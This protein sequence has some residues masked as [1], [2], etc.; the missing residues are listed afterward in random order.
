MLV[1]QPFLQSD[2]GL[3]MFKPGKTLLSELAKMSQGN[4]LVVM[5]LPD[6]LVNVPSGKLN[7]PVIPDSSNSR[8][9]DKRLL[10]FFTHPTV[11]RRLGDFNHWVE[12]IP[13][14]QLSDGEYC[15]QN[16]T[17]LE[18]GRGAVRLCWYHDN[19]YRDTPSERCIELAER[20]VMLFS[21]ERVRQQ[22]RLEQGRALSLQELGWWSIL[23]DVYDQ[24]PDSVISELIGTKRKTSGTKLSPR[25]ESDERF[26]D[27]GKAVIDGR[28]KAISLT[29]DPEP[30][31]MFMARPKEL[32]WHSE[33]YLQFVRSLPCVITGKTEGVVAH[34]LIGH[35]EGKMGGKTHDLFTIPLAADEHRRFH[36]DPRGWEARHGSQLFYVKQTIKR[37]MELGALV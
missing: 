1:L 21:L 31:A 14:C 16:L 6:E 35:G 11:R 28:V 26:T 9:G 5:P 33:K 10:E 19:Q 24:L 3:M 4:R 17:V 29:I 30:P 32:T 12:R 7:R 20:N 27:N 15:D 2:L 13:H 34:H 18:C 22:L 25:R 36:D 23:N 37:A 8:V